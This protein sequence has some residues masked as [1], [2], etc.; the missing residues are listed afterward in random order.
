MEKNIISII[1]KNQLY[2]LLIKK[3]RRFKKKGVDFITNN[4]DLLQL[5][6]L[7]HKKNHKIKS[8]IHSKE[9]RVINYCTEVLLIEKGKLKVSFF[10]N[11]G[12]NIKKDKVINK[13]DILILFKGGHGFTCYSNTQIIEVKQG[14]Y[15][16]NKDKKILK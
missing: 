4:K 2:A 14:P 7:N 13:G 5:V 16:M 12:K 15:L 10:D 1:H 8:H 6:F 11:K 3:S 9:K